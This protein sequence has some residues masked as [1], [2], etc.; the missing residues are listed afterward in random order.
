MDNT[1]ATDQDLDPANMLKWYIECGVDECISENETNWF[2]EASEIQVIQ[3]VSTTSS[4]EKKPISRPVSKAPL[5]SNKEIISNAEKLVAQCTSLE[6]LNEAILSFEDC[7]L[8]NTASN[9]VYCDGN[10]Q[11]DIMVIGEAP[12]VDEDRDGKPF[13]GECGQLLNKMFAAIN[14]TRENDFY[15]TNLVPWRPPGN[16]KPTSAEC[17]ICLPFLKRHIELF[18]PK[19]IILVGGTSANAL[20]DNNIGITKLRGKWQEYEMDGKQIPIVSILHP[21]YL[22]RQPNCKKQ[23]WHDLLSIKERIGTLEK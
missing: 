12:G 7:S 21:E 11:S 3:K 23:T 22:I 20:L 17:D 2:D 1:T 16:R 13:I 10:P 9:T 19:M 8:K 18:N 5:V 6:A 4:S 14:M 15:I